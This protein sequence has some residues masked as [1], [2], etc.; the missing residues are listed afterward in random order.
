VCCTRLCCGELG[1]CV[2]QERTCTSSCTWDV[3]YDTG[4]C[5]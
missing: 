3:W 4:T 2:D 5:L 1:I